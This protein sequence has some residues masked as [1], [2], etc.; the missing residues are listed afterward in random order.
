MTICLFLIGQMVKYQ[1]K[2]FTCVTKNIQD[3]GSILKKTKLF[4]QR[5]SESMIKTTLLSWQIYIQKYP[6][7]VEKNC[8][9]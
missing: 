5:F 2:D 3:S 6:Q 8:L 9:Y 7:Q 4:F 1:R